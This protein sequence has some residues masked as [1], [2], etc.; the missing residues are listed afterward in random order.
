MKMNPEV[1][2]LECKSKVAEMNVI[3]A[4]LRKPLSTAQPDEMRYLRIQ[5]HPARGHPSVDLFNS[6]HNC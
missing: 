6:E 1:A 4:D 2:G 5:F 3:D